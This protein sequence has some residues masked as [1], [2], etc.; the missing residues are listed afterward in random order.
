MKLVGVAGAVAIASTAD[1]GPCA[2]ATQRKVPS[3]FGRKRSGVYRY[4]R[5]VVDCIR[6][7]QPEQVFIP[8]ARRK[9]VAAVN[10]VLAE[11]QYRAVVSKLTAV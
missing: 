3:R 4:C 8:R 5:G 6:T 1:H 2:P 9:Q 10:E 11:L 7:K